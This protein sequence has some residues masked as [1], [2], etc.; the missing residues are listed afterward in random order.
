MT[1]WL[2]KPLNKICSTQKQAKTTKL[3]TSK[4]NF[5]PEIA[6][7]HSILKES[8]KSKSNA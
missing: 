6:Q 2:N 8:N 5:K 4:V 7:N 3:D 1:N